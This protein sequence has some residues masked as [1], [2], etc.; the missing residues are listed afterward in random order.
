MARVLKVKIEELRAIDAEG[1]KVSPGDLIFSFV[2]TRITAIGFTSLNAKV[3]PSRDR[4]EDFKM[5]VF[6]Y[7]LVCHGPHRCQWLGHELR[8]SRVIP[9]QFRDPDPCLSIRPNRK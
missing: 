1:S 2:D 8:D 3:I 6:D 4:F 9:L 7:P 5:G